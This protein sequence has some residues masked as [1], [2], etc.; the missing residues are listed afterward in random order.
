MRTF[1][2]FTSGAVGSRV[3]MEGLISVCPRCGRSGIIEPLADGAREFVHVQ[4]EE[5]MGD[6]MLVEP[7]DWCR[8]RDV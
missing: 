2:D 4:I 3:P 6:G 5:V 7:I 8:V 1:D